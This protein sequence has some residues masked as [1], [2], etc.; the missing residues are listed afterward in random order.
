M[1]F[2]AVKDTIYTVQA[3]CQQSKTPSRRSRTPQA[4]QATIYKYIL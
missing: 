3:P 2:L 1:N 4:F